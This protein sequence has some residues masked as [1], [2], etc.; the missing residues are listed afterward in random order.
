M[1]VFVHEVMKNF[2][3]EPFELKPGIPV[4]MGDAC[5]AA[6]CVNYPD[7][8]IDGKEKFD[9]FLLSQKINDAKGMLTA[10]TTPSAFVELTVE[11]VTLIKKLMGKAYAVGLV[12]ACYQALE[13]NRDA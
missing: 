5:I 4:T 10:P 8:Q 6:L 9:R 2:E 7:E 13:K 12:G 11:E 1:K 3:G